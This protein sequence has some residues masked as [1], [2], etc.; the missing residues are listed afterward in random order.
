[1]RAVRCS[2]SLSIRLKN[3]Q[4]TSEAAW[5][6][7]RRSKAVFTIIGAMAELERNVSP[8]RNAPSSSIIEASPISRRRFFGS[9][10]RRRLIRR[11]TCGGV[12]AGKADQSVSLLI[13]LAMT[14]ATV[15]G[16]GP[17]RAMH[18]GAAT[19]NQ[20]SDRQGEAGLRSEYQGRGAPGSIGRGGQAGTGAR[21]RVHALR[22]QPQEGGRD[23]ESREETARPHEG[24][25]RIGPQDATY[26]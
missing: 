23:R 4:T 21:Q 9:L 12:S 24:R 2:S 16:G 13:T 15:P 5:P 19:G 17:R 3:R 22:C 6:C 11:R 7:N 8:G 10:R 1:M 14:S 26:L 25:Q 20:Q 18:R